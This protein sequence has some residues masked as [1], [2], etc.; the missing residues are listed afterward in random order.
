MTDTA[1]AR[2]G[3]LINIKFKSV[4]K[5]LRHGQNV[6]VLESAKWVGPFPTPLSGSL[7]RVNEGFQTDILLLNKDPYG[8][9]WLAQLRP[10]NAEEERAG[11]LTGA[12]AFEAYRQKIDELQIH[13]IRCAD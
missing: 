8:A 1:Q 7:T 11:L 6:A 9:G 10:T 2:L 12:A 3:K 13:C 4:G 5:V